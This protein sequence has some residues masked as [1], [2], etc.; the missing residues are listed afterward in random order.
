MGEPA[1]CWIVSVRLLS[2]LDPRSGARFCA[3]AGPL[4]RTNAN[5]VVK[6]KRSIRDMTRSGLRVSTPS[7]SLSDR[8]L[9]DVTSWQ[10]TR[11]GPL[12]SVDRAARRQHGHHLEVE[13]LGEP[14]NGDFGRNAHPLLGEQKLE[15]VDTADGLCVEADDSI[16]QA[17]T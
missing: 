8:F 15:G 9:R 11:A 1:I 2:G 10:R 6:A 7:S 17:D 16:P 5:A 3:A 14:Q 12:A 4:V 13:L